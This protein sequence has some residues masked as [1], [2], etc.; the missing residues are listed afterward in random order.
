[1]AFPGLN[2]SVLSYKK[3]E[4]ISEQNYMQQYIPFGAGFGVCINYG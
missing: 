2:Q 1:M 3:L 4:G